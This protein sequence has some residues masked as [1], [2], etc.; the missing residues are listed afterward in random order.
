MRHARL[1]R[2]LT[3][4]TVSM[5]TAEF[6]EVQKLSPTD[7]RTRFHLPASCDPAV[8]ALTTDPAV[9]SLTVAVDC[10]GAGEPAAPEP[11]QRRGP[12][13]PLKPGP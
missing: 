4:V 7:L 3:A 9:N 13:R 12:S 10:R 6:V 2:I 5:S 11:G 1:I 8:T